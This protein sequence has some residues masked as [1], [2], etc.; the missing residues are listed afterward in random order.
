MAQHPTVARDA[1]PDPGTQK[2]VVVTIMPLTRSPSAP[3]PRRLRP[4]GPHCRGGASSLL[5]LSNPAAA[6]LPKAPDLADWI[7][8]AATSL[9]GAD[10]MPAFAASEFTG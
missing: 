3:A 8:R 10:R 5:R 6:R 2:D 9:L 4:A 1:A 7:Q